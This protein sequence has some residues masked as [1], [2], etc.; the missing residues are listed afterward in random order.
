MSV[1]EE[2]LGPCFNFMPGYETFWSYVPHFIHSPFYVYA[3]AM[4]WIRASIQE[5]HTP[6]S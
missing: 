1:Q 3:Y 2:S 4:G 5:Y 6:A